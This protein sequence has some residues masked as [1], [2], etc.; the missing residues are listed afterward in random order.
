MKKILTIIL[1]FCFAIAKAQ[2]SLPEISLK[3]LSG[4]EVSLTSL[5]EDKTVVV[6]LWATWCV[7]CIRELDTIAEVYEE[8]Q[9]EINFELVAISVDDSRST[10]RVKPAVMGK[11]WEYTV[12]LDPNN[13]VRRHLG[14]PNVPL[15]LIIKNGEIVYRH[16]SFTPG[17]EDELF[18]K[19]KEIA[20]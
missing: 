16:S 19:F 18:E 3:N 4:K 2:T 1:I 7:P 11:G 5:S 10:R 13:D 15:T 9:E 20:G 8:M 14:N 6:S 12:L 17:A